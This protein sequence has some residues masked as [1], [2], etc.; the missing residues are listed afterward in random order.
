MRK[1]VCFFWYEQEKWYFFYF[2]GM[3][4]V[5]KHSIELFFLTFGS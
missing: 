4:F 3:F 2:Y 1:S 5:K